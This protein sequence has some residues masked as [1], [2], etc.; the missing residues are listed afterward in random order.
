[1]EQEQ[2]YESASNI[3]RGPLSG[4]QL[5]G[6]MCWENEKWKFTE[7]ISRDHGL[8]PFFAVN[9]IQAVDSR[10]RERATQDVRGRDPE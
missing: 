3:H 1:M 4:S 6:V 10:G 7:R 9:E 8:L 5:L 2:D